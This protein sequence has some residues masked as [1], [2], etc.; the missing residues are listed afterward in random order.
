MVASSILLHLGSAEGR[1]HDW[2][3]ITGLTN[4]VNLLAY[5]WLERSLSKGSLFYLS[6]S[7]APVTSR[8]KPNRRT[9]VSVCVRQAVINLCMGGV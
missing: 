9:G 1:D 8:E 3:Q 6:F 4:K 2:V 5:S 7:E